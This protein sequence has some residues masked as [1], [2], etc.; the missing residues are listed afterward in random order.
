MVNQ[1]IIIQ[2]VVFINFQMLYTS[3]TLTVTP[4]ANHI[5]RASS[6]S[7]VTVPDL[8]SFQQLLHKATEALASGQDLELQEFERSCGIPNRMLLPKGKPNGMD[9]TLVVAVS[10]GSEDR[11]AEFE[12][13][14]E[15]STT[16]AHCG[17]HG[18]KYPDKRPM[19]YPLERR[20]SDQR[21]ILDT[22]NIKHTY[23]KIYHD[24]RD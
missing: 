24:E 21:V 20:I 18:Q 3:Y 1:M 11:V 19:G 12:E 23:V 14:L 22:P 13:E 4:G 8:P 2:T 16:H 5:E 7:S 17:I 6:Q 9:F 15:D 10:N